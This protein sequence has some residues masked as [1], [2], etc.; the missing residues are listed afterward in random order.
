MATNTHLFETMAGSRVD[1]K[2]G[3]IYG[4]AIIS[5]GPTKNNSIADRTT[6]EQV[7]NEGNAAPS[8]VKVKLRHKMKGEF[9]SILES[10][11]GVVKNFSVTQSGKTIANL[12]VLNSLDEKLKSKLFEMAETMPEEFGLSVDI[13]DE[14]EK[15]DGKTYVRCEE[16]HSVDLTEAPAANPNGLFESM[17]IKYKHGESGEHH[18]SCECKECKME[19]R[20]KKMETTLET[21]TASIA[22]ITTKLESVK[23]AATSPAPA[24][25]TVKKDGKDVEVTAQQ[26]F[27]AV[28]VTK[29]ASETAAAAATSA[30][31]R[32]VLEK[33]KR[34]GRVAKNPE[35]GIAYTVEQLEALPLETL[36]FAAVNSERIPL[37]AV[38]IFKG[39]Q[40]GGKTIDPNL[41]GSDAIRAQLEAQGFGDINNV[42][43]GLAGANA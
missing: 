18:E 42:L 4:V 41:K 24:T 11:V 27:E 19:S 5:A 35:T 43:G 33:M 8:G 12:H 9:Q 21:L 25:F 1:R 22:V 32:E 30:A 17:S 31:R 39:D 28:E 23:P 14:P 38:A 2:E 40:K 20:Q 7:A 37:E 29:K 26:L 3:I 13:A 15:K 36:K 6:L 34:E 16:L 10:C